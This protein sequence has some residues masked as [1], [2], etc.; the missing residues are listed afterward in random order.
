MTT[1][2]ELSRQLRQEFQV[3]QEIEVEVFRDGV[4]ETLLVVLGERPP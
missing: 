2:R 1:V 3:G 4:R